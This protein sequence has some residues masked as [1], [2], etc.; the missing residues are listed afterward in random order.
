MFLLK[1]GSNNITHNFNRP[2]ST[3]FSS[4]NYNSRAG[5]AAPQHNITENRARP[6]ALFLDLLVTET[7]VGSDGNSVYNFVELLNTEGMAETDMAA[8]KASGGLEPWLLQ[9]PAAAKQTRRQRRRHRNPRRRQHRGPTTTVAVSL[10]CSV[11]QRRRWDG[12]V[13]EGK[14]RWQ[15][16]QR[17]SSSLLVSH[18]LLSVSLSFSISISL[19]VLASAPAAPW[20]SIAGAVVHLLPPVSKPVLPFPLAFCVRVFVYR[21]GWCI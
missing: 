18:S 16:M 19:F 14:A 8:V 4:S 13:S 7:V 20:P 9:A 6:T 5:A 10:S 15:G 11:L 3:K 2:T 1:H 21:L 12:V 17:R